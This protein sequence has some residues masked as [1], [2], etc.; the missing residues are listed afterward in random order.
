MGKPA[1]FPLEVR[2]LSVRLGGH[3][4]LRDVSFAFDGRKRVV[5][6]GA[7]GA[8]KS[9]LL[10]TLHGLI[11][12]TAGSIR[13]ANSSQRAASQAMVFQ[14][15][16]ML[17]RPAL[18]NIAYALAVSG[19]AEPERSRRA[20]EAI[21]HVGLAHLSQRQARVLSGG[22]QQRIALAR[23]WSLKPRMLFLD[24]PTASLDPAA[25]GEVERIVTRIHGEGTAVVM[26]THNLGLARRF[27]DEIVF[28]HEGRLTEHTAA[29]LFFTAPASPEAARFLQGELPWSIAS[30]PSSPA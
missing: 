29:D 28:L 8:G 3:E 17:R 24:E 18:A 6:L 12:P 10:R 4:A 27:A 5:V 9:V 30:Q 2:G 13:W 14:R 15:S 23:A 16:V 22:E 11:A 7:N 19:V 20:R 25:A 21:E 1:I 26:T